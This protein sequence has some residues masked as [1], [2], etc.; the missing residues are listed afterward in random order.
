MDRSC[1]D[2]KNLLSGYLDHVLTENEEYEVE[3]HLSHCDECRGALHDFMKITDLFKEEKHPKAPDDFLAGVHAKIEAINNETVVEQP[4]PAVDVPESN[5]EVQDDRSENIIPEISEIEQKSKLSLKMPELS[6]NFNFLDG[7]LAFF[8][9]HGLTAAVSL[10]TIGFFMFMF[11]K[12]TGIDRPVYMDAV[13]DVAIIDEKVKTEPIMAEEELTVEIKSDVSEEPKVET[14]KFDSSPQASALFS[15]VKGFPLEE[16]TSEIENEK[17]LM[18]KG[19]YAG[20]AY[21]DTDYATQ[22][23][24]MEGGYAEHGHILGNIRDGS[25]YKLWSVDSSGDIPAAALDSSAQLKKSLVGDDVVFKI[26]ETTRGNY[27]SQSDIVH[28]VKSIV[29]EEKSYKS[30]LDQYES[31][32]DVAGT[33]SLSESEDELVLTD[34]E[35]SV[36]KMAEAQA[37]QEIDLEIAAFGKTLDGESVDVEEDKYTQGAVLADKKII[38]IVSEDPNESLGIVRD[39]LNKHDLSLMSLDE[40]ESPYILS[41]YAKYGAMLTFLDECRDNIENVDDYLG[42]SSDGLDE[43]TLFYIQIYSQ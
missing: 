3:V 10:C 38:T 35:R 9:G 42:S 17:S 26:Q 33:Y 18:D 43:T 36:M 28:Q 22:D 20:I 39:L 37:M 6:F 34:T 41:V 2:I 32:D 27:K 31:K 1:E 19:D 7:L 13:S 21:S 16:T 12:D 11:L 29:P 14:F 24:G 4:A 23:K 40:S 25:A 8:K 5:I 30:F 15:E